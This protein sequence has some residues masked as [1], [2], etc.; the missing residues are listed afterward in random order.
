MYGWFYYETDGHYQ[1]PYPTKEAAIA[2]G[3]V[4]TD[5][6]RGF[7]IME[8]K[9]PPFD[10]PDADQLLALFVEVN[11]E[12]GT[13]EKPFGIEGFEATPEQK[14]HLEVAFRDLFSGWMEQ[15]Q[16]RFRIETFRTIQNVELIAAGNVENDADGI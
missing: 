11:S 7:W 14:A 4:M 12:L 6:A 5:V 15:Y 9:R 16:I 10:F 8:G 3:R 2:A 1:G 13:P